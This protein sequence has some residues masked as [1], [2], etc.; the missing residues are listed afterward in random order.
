MGSGHVTV[1]VGEKNADDTSI[2][3]CVVDDIVRPLADLAPVLLGQGKRLNFVGGM[4]FPI[5]EGAPLF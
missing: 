3:V 1:K 5:C 4:S 2:N